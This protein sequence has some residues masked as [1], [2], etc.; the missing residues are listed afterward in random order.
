MN[1]FSIP[2]APAWFNALLNLSAQATILAGL[3]WITLKMVGR[4][5]PPSWRALM[6]FVVILRLLIPFS[7]PSPFSLQN[8][9]TVEAPVVET[10]APVVQVAP[11]LPTVYLPTP[12]PLELASETIS[13]YA[14]PLSPA[15]TKP[16]RYTRVFTWIWGGAASFLIALLGVRALVI[17]YR[18]VRHGSPPAPF[19]LELLRACCVRMRLRYPIR[20]TASDRVAAPALT[21]LVPA[22]LIIPSAFGTP[23]FAVSEIRQIFM[24]ELSHL[25]QGHLILHWL[26]LIA[27]AIH[28]F[29]PAI[30]FA[31]LRMRQE[32]ELAADA[33]AV[34][35]ANA[36]ERAAYGETML[37]VLQNSIAPPTLLALGMAEQTRHLKE[38]LKALKEPGQTRSYLLTAA[39]LCALVICGFSSASPTRPTST[40]PRNEAPVREMAMQA[41]EETP[42][43]R[44]KALVS[45]NFTQRTT[46]EVA[47]E[48]IRSG[49]I[50]GAESLLQKAVNDGTLN[51]VI[52]EKITTL[53]A[54]TNIVL[55]RT[56]LIETNRAALSPNQKRLIEKLATIH[57]DDF[58]IA[59][60]VDL[61]EVLKE[62]GSELRRRDP[63]RR[64]INLIIVQPPAGPP[65]APPPIDLERFQIKF[66]PPIRDVTLGQLFDTIVR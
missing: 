20:I 36:E 17:R 42:A 1:L 56:N 15:Q 3:V 31:A 34:I 29:N 18:L 51:S 64:G 57:V 7:P 9:F 21:G 12:A 32:C 19:I 24:H 50:E 61:V 41:S 44:S 27:R 25:Q 39:L 23:R 49:D 38:R 66:D 33:A 45:T 43:N 37:K 60:E 47:R 59:S 40:A 46:V 4:W 55:A 6:W 63:A 54:V 62:L 26:A 8:L 58:P 52:N 65:N 53:T 5:I 14:A 16:I 22:R 35:D 30:H 10:A 11:Q 2:D 48:L 13:S 28:W